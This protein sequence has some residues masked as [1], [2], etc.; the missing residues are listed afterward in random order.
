MKNTLKAKVGT[1]DTGIPA[2]IPAPSEWP[3]RPVYLRAE[4]ETTLQG[5]NDV[6]SVGKV[7]DFET[8]LFRGKVMI[9]LEPI[10][11]N[12]E[13]CNV[14]AYAAYFEGRKRFYELVVQ[15]QFKEELGW[16]EVYFGDVYSKPLNGVPNG[17]LM[18]LAQKFMQTL[19]PGM[20]FDV[21]SDKPRVLT[22]AGSAQTI[23]ID[24][25]GEEPEIDGPV[26]IVEHTNEDLGKKFKTSNE[27]RKYMSKPKN[28]RKYKLDPK[29]V[30]TFELYDHSMNFGTYHQHMMGGKNDMVKIV[31]GQPLAFAC[32]TKDDRYVFRFA[33]WHER[34]LESMK[35]EA[36]NKTKT[37]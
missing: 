14:D 35:A 37:K 16:D 32:L 4:A 36:A 5:E 11:P 25:L 34:L 1:E 19:S 6:F 24:T 31:N 21:A 10:V 33:V 13:D 7:L 22:L 2:D 3:N 15:G 12:A 29:K 17:M 28:A 27:R 18:K 8:D 26:G 23:R 30:Y 9:R 20:I